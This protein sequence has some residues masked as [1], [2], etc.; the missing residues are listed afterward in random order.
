ME[1][2]GNIFDPRYFLF[3]DEDVVFYRKEKFEV[4]SGLPCEL[5]VRDKRYDIKSLDDICKSN[6]I[7]K[8]W[9]RYVAVG[10]WVTELDPLDPS[11]KELLYCGIKE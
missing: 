8:K 5:I 10:K 2:N 7:S 6:N 3:D 11:A 1:K 4:G 9:S